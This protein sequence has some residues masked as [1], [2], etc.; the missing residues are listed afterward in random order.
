MLHLNL[1]KHRCSGK[2][3]LCGFTGLKPA[4]PPHE[5]QKPSWGTSVEAAPSETEQLR[6]MQ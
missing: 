1:H 4:S 2:A 5:T 6:L 3:F